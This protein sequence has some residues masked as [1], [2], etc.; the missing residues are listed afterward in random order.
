MIV[1]AIVLTS[2]ALGVTLAVLVGKFLRHGNERDPPSIQPDPVAE[3]LPPEID[4]L[5]EPA[6]SIAAEFYSM[7]VPVVITYEDDG[8]PFSAPPASKAPPW[9]N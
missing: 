7:G 2:I 8:D 9:A 3:P 1:A 4:N 5:P 6:R